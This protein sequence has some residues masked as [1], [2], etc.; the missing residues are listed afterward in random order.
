MIKHENLRGTLIETGQ[1]TRVGEKQSKNTVVIKTTTKDQLLPE[2]F[3]E[4]I[5][6]S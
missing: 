2:V 4:K 6:T 5:T 3:G 1:E